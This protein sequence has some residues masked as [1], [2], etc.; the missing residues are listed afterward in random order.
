M[1]LFHSLIHE[2]RCIGN[3]E[4]VVRV[5]DATKSNYPFPAIRWAIAYYKKH[6]KLTIKQR[7]CLERFLVDHLMFLPE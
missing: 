1:R 4:L 5:Y 7:D 6:R 2:I 3:H